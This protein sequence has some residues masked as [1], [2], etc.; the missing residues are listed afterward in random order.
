MITEVFHKT[1][2]LILDDYPNHQKLKSELIE[3]LENYP[4]VQNKE[5]NVKATM[6]EWNISSPQ[7]EILKQ[8]IL[9]NSFY[10]LWKTANPKIATFWANVY[11]KKEYTQ[12]HDHLPHNLSF[13]YFLN[14]KNYFSSLYFK[15]IGFNKKI[16]PKEG[17]LI[18]FPS[19]LKHGVK[20]HMYQEYR[21]TLSGDILIQ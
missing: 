5:T 7:I 2:L 12:L 6:T 19:Y 20:R 13:V 18:I 9:H 1:K 8:Y 21:I 17:R 14:S 4:D 15:T 10:F 16:K 11:R 3:T